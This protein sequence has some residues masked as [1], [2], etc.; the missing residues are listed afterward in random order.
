MHHVPFKRLVIALLIMLPMVIWAGQSKQENKLIRDTFRIDIDHIEVD[1]D[2][3][4]ETWTMVGHATLEF[5]MLPGQKEPVVHLGSD[6]TADGIQA[7]VLNGESL[8][9]NSSDVSTTQLSGSD[10]HSLVLHRN[11][12]RGKHTLEIHYEKYNNWEI[13][14]PIYNDGNG[15]GADQYFPTINS[16]FER[17]THRLSFHF[18]GETPFSFIGSETVTEEEVEEGQKWTVEVM[19]PVPSAS[20]MWAA[21]PQ[22][23]VVNE[24][25]VIDGVKVS[26]MHWLG[27]GDLDEAFA[28]VEAWIPRLRYDFG[29][30]PHGPSFNM[31][32]TPFDGG[33]L[34][35]YGGAYVSMGAIKHELFHA[36]YA[37]SVIFK[38]YRD[39]WLDEALNVWYEGVDYLGN[40]VE[41]VPEDFSSNIAVDRTVV[42]LG[43]D[44]R[45]YQEGAGVI[46]RA[47]QEMGGRQRMIDFLA[48]LHLRER[49]GNKLNTNK[50]VERITDFDGTDLTDEFEQ[51]VGTEL[52]QAAKTHATHKS[53]PYHSID[54]EAMMG[55]RP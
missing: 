50:F 30:L 48:W 46:A 47:A 16:P 34:E 29:P 22:S 35:F 54:I 5:R 53:N 10:Q 28:T 15:L 42:D 27:G 9:P 8:D 4:P 44:L 19:E 12:K 20:V 43:F 33:G 38:S 13:W 37:N 52:E 2:I 25:R 49:L 11:L 17:A 24:T 26:I 23:W 32:L 55:C 51:W 41:M 45:A 6:I 31:L 14:F 3:F 40:P 21:L 36:Y 39:S 18:H 7:I 1:F